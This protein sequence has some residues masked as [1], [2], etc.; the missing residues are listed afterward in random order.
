MK[1]ALIAGATGLIGSSLVQY[2]LESN[3]YQ[4]VIALVRKP[5][6]T[7]HPKLDEQLIDFD[8]LHNLFLESKVHDVFCCLGTTIKKAGSQDAFSKVD[9]TYVLE[10]ARW[11]DK[12]E[13]QLLSV[14]SSVGAKV[15]TS[16]FYLRTKGQMEEAISSLTIP[17]VHLFR[18]S[19][20][21]GQRNEFRLAEK[22]SEK[23]MSV[24]NPLLNGRLRKYRA[25]QAHDVALAMHNQAQNNVIGIKVFEGAEIK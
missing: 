15:N 7:P 20:L 3:E 10:L 18:P 5:S 2:L 24:L 6:I 1:T 21:L 22:V 14:V 25:I 8:D 11:A 4:K 19:L 12:H 16:N 13:C 9:Y 17:T 23:V